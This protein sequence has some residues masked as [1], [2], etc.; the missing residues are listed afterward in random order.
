MTKKIVVKGARMHNLKNVDVEIPREKLVVVTGVSGSG[1]SSLA[2]DT[3]YAEGQRRY[4]ESLSTYARQFLQ[5]QEKPEVDSIDGLSPAIS[6]DQKSAPRNPR[7]TVGTVTEM[8]DYLRLLF[9][10]VGTPINPENGRELVSQTPA[11]ILNALNKWEDG[12]KYMILAPVVRGRKGEHTGEIEKVQKAGFVRLRVNGEIMTINEDIEL[13]PQKK[14]NIEIVVDRLVKSD[15]SKQYV[16]LDGGDKVEEKNDDRMRVIDSIET[17]L[18]FGEGIM[19]AHKLADESD[20]LYSELLS[21]PETGFS[22]PPL[23]PR[24]FSFNS[25]H[26]ACDACHG[27]GYRL[28]LNPKTAINGKLS[29][30][31]GGIL[32]WST[33]GSNSLAWYTSV[34]KAVGEKYGFNINQPM[35]EISEE[36]ITRIIKGTGTE[37]FIVPLNGAFRGKTTETEFEGAATQ[38]EKRF[39]DA[40]SDFLR[41]KLEGFMIESTCSECS[42]ARLNIYGRNVFIAGKSIADITGMQIPNV[43]KWIES[44]EETEENEK[45]LYAILVIREIKNPSI[46]PSAA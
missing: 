8:Y 14:H 13:D 37:K 35:S 3:I 10:K 46:P 25:P 4:V 32:P 33:L 12:E 29:I 22:F 40:E 11:Q 18:K 39:N 45:I 41:K 26:G 28:E 38:T 7:S 20:H 44:V 15:Y 30:R 1:K 9:A 36:N 19:I 24:M 5:L 27:L 17:A 31:E 42:G 21:D 6:I 34:V 43:K 16:E 2:F 23:E